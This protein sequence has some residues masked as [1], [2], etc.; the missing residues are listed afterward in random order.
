MIKIEKEENYK[1]FRFLKK[2]VVAGVGKTKNEALMTFIEELNKRIKHHNDALFELREL[3]K[4][5]EEYKN[6]DEYC[7]L[8]FVTVED[9]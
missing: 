6:S 1:I 2:D 5:V 8:P 7:G 9:K 3:E 4:E